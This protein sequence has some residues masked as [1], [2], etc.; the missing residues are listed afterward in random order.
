ML[1]LGL[2]MLAGT[3]VAAPSVKVRI[4]DNGYGTRGRPPAGNVLQLGETVTIVVEVNDAR[5]GQP[6][7]LPAV[8]GLTLN[9]TGADAVMKNK[10]SLNYF[11]T[12]TS[13]GDMVI[14]AFA[15]HPGDRQ[16][17][18]TGPIQLHALAK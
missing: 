7:A 5:V 1:F 13:A 9:G 2:A 6:P 16:I 15:I 12:P 17:V 14:P 4:E 8:N 18:T 3:A 10:V 11:V